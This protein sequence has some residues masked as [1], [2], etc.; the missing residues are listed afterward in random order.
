MAQKHGSRWGCWSQRTNTLATQG[1]AYTADTKFYVPSPQLPWV[2]MQIAGPCNLLQ[3]FTLGQESYFTFREPELKIVK[4]LYSLRA[5]CA[6]WLVHPCKNPA[7]F[8]WDGNKVWYANVLQS[9]SWDQAE[10]STLSGMTVFI[11][12]FPLLLSPIPLTSPTERT[13]L[14]K[15]FIL[16]HNLKQHGKSLWPQ[17]SVQKW[18]WDSNGLAHQNLRYF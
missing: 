17:R 4:R 5:T 10:A 8:L 6:Q 16:E 13:S 18:N 3:R 9:S 12:C 14:I 2:M 15:P 1:W 11:G 7:P